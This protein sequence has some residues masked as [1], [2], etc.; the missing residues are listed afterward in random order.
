MKHNQS[1]SLESHS[2]MFIKIA[3]NC[4]SSATIEEESTME[5]DFLLYLRAPT[6][7]TAPTVE[8]V[9]SENNNE[10]ENKFQLKESTP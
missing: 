4:D 8:S 10:E 6:I 1:S 3:K 5:K 2:E 9:I 7:Q